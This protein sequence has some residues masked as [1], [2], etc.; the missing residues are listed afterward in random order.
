MPI[1]LTDKVAW[2]TG[3]SR[4]IGAV[5]ARRFAERGARV[6]A[7]CLG[8][9]KDSGGLDE[10]FR[11]NSPRSTVLHQDVRRPEDGEAVA[12]WIRDHADRLDVLV[13]NAGID[14]RKPADEMSVEHW[15]EVLSVNL[16]GSFYSCRAALPLMKERGYGKIIQVGSIMAFFGGAKVAHYVSSKMGLIGLTRGLARDLGRFGIRVNCVAPG[17][18]FMPLPPEE[19]R[20]EIEKTMNERQCLPGLMVAEDIEPT[21]AFL[22]SEDS[23]AITGQCIT[24]DRGWTHY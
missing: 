10:F 5:L 17:A 15:R 6:V 3:T 20:G 23:D 16:D 14:P 12:A 7:T 19:R 2:I 9:A 22:A 18:I 4:G 24:V 11:E 1:T 13:N 8:G 21:Y